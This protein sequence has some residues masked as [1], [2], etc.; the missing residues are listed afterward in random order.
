MLIKTV[1]VPV[2][3]VTLKG[4]ESVTRGLETVVEAARRECLK[5]P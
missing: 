1:R 2:K 3:A 4:P 5:M